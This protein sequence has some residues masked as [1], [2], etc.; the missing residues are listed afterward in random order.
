MSRISS[1]EFSRYSVTQNDVVFQLPL[2][3][4][5]SFHLVR[6]ALSLRVSSGFLVPHLKTIPLNSMKFVKLLSAEDIQEIVV[7]MEEVCPELLL[8][9]VYLP[10]HVY[11]IQSLTNVYAQ[12]QYLSTRQFYDDG[13]FNRGNYLRLCELVNCIHNNKTIKQRNGELVQGVSQLWTGKQGIFRGNIGG[14]RRNL[15]FR[16][17]AVP[18]K[19]TGIEWVTLPISMQSKLLAPRFYSRNLEERIHISYVVEVCDGEDSETYVPYRQWKHRN[20][21]KKLEIGQKVI[22]PLQH[23]DVVVIN[24]QPSLRMQNLIG[25]R[26]RFSDDVDNSTIGVNLAVT[27]FLGGD[28]DGDE[29]NGWCVLDTL[30]FVEA[31]LWLSP[32]M[33]KRDW[34]TNEYALAHIQDAAMGD[35]ILNNNTRRSCD[36][37]SNMSI[38]QYE[39]L[40]KRGFSHAT[41]TG[42][43]ISLDGLRVPQTE[44]YDRDAW[45][46]MVESGA[47]GKPKNLEQMIDNVGVQIVNGVHCPRFPFK[48]CPEDGT[49]QSSYLSGLDIGEYFMHTA[50]AR[51]GL[52]TSAMLTAITGYRGRMLNH[53]LSTTR[54]GLVAALGCGREMTQAQLSSFHSTGQQSLRNEVAD[55]V[56]LLEGRCGGPKAKH[57][58]LID[59]DIV[60]CSFKD[61]DITFIPLS[62]MLSTHRFVILAFQFAMKIEIDQDIETEFYHHQ[63]ETTMNSWLNS[64]VETTVGEKEY[65]IFVKWVMRAKLHERILH[66]LYDNMSFNK[67]M[68]CNDIAYVEEKHGVEFAKE[69]LMWNFERSPFGCVKEEQRRLIVDAVFHSGTYSSITRNGDAYKSKGPLAR[70]LIECPY[71]ELVRAMENGET[72][73]LCDIES[74][75]VCSVFG[76]SN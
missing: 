9:G 59:D 62:Q 7:V 19:E 24:R 47:K 1:V 63:D 75:L 20:P 53:A 52:I 38:S 6:K 60:L 36:E 44:G 18:N 8:R 74:Q 11:H 12:V 14:K 73:T 40:Q 70:A 39:E 13:K 23:G 41:E 37:L 3:V 64:I 31:A 68:S 54:D 76:E 51:E 56:A 22:T 33:N 67:R 66:T 10:R 2:I 46:L 27:T 43:S 28:F 61:L 58:A 29:F 71:R 26:V 16:S 30:A 55:I 32:S 65:S 69:C 50:A 5:Q 48:D 42:Y 21:E 34:S 15:T 45:R 4:N 49:I 35:Y 57:I 17:V 25:M 72:D